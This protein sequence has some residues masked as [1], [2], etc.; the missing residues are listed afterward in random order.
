MK[1]IFNLFLL[2]IVHLGFSQVVTYNPPVN[3][4]NLSVEGEK[5]FYKKGEKALSIYNKMESESLE[6]S[7]LSVEER[8]FIENFSE[9]E[10]Y[11]S[12]VGG[13]C[14]WY[15]GGGPDSVTSTSHLESQGSANYQPSNAH[16]LDYKTAWVEGVKGN[17]IGEKLI[18]HF[19]QNSPRINEINIVNGY[20][21]S[22]N[23]Y[24]NNSRAKKL[25]IYF[26]DTPI[27]IVNLK[28][29]RGTSTIDIPL[30]GIAPELRTDVKAQWTLTFEILDYYQGEKYQDLAIS[31]IYFDGIDVHCLAKGTE[32]LMS[33]S[34]LKKVEELSINDEILSYN[35]ITKQ[36]VIDT[37]QELAS[38]FHSNLA[39]IIF[40]DSTSISCTQDHPLLSENNK[41]RSLSPLNTKVNY[42]GF[43]N[44]QLLQIGDKLKTANGFKTINSITINNSLVR[45]YTIVKLKNN[46]T[47]I[48]NSIIVGT[49]EL[50]NP[51]VLSN[52]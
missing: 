2:S 14:S 17:G 43:S 27:A 25:K 3:Y 22:E 32:I 50:I 46:R 8:T 15:C 47:F 35:L 51:E 45:T 12:P 42:K 4:L 13:G 41:W 34:T 29:V 33:D 19:H 1:S 31:E 10:S 37:I 21:K 26:N 30:L 7:D 36:L 6:L 48:A 18:Y 16:D 24:K 9:T 11:C 49:E 28:D 38:P 20:V 23:A 44:I 5:E 39:N 52:K 40:T